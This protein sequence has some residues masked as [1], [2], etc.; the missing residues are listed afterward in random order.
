MRLSIALGLLAF[1]C[2]QKQPGP[3]EVVGRSMFVAVEL[4]AETRWIYASNVENGEVD[5]PS[6]L[7]E[8]EHRVDAYFFGCSLEDFGVAPGTSMTM[9]V[10][11]TPAYHPQPL[12][13]FTTIVGGSGSWAATTLGFDLGLVDPCSEYIVEW[14]SDP[15][16][17][18][19]DAET[20]WVLP[21]DDGLW[22]GSTNGNLYR[23]EAGAGGAELER[24]ATDV[25]AL[26]MTKIGPEF[27]GLILADASATMAMVRAGPS[28]SAFDREIIGLSNVSSPSRLRGRLGAGDG[29]ELALSDRRSLRVQEG[30]DWK[31]GSDLCDE[32]CVRV[33][34]GDVFLVHSVALGFVPSA[35]GIGCIG[36]KNV[37]ASL[38]L[39]FA[40]SEAC[41][42]IG[43]LA[44]HPDFDLIASAG[45]AVYALQEGAWVESF[46][47]ESA[48]ALAAVGDT[49]VVASGTGL[50]EHF[51]SGRPACTHPDVAPIDGSTR[52]IVPIGGGFFVVSQNAE[53]Q[54]SVSV[55]REALNTCSG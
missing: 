19:V 28:P 52:S 32:A 5:F 17:L 23:V 46:P 11:A 55:I 43:G 40:A 51:R 25:F 54:L 42:Q 38:P 37:I 14:M 22:I 53:D 10:T 41:P 21:E 24:I 2:V 6:I 44:F 4:D 39:A 30:N 48:G 29:P 15:G 47:A 12:K 31:G 50:I 8:G 45:D 1:A 49:I 7:L 34:M 20:A 36:T 35:A 13:A 27:F 18:D 3:P 33:D 26:D 9:T 16:A